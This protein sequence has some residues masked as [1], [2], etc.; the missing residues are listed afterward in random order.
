MVRLPAIRTALVTLALFAGVACVSA[1][2]SETPVSLRSGTAMQLQALAS[3]NHVD[4]ILM[5]LDR[6]DGDDERNR[7]WDRDDHRDK[8]GDKDRDRDGDDKQSS[9]HAPSPTPEPSTLLSFGAAALIGGAVIYSRR[10][11]RNRK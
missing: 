7:G 9:P 3:T 8:D 11:L 1:R 4:G 2:T 5:L 10:L 6:R